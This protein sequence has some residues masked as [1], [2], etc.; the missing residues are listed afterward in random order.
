MSPNKSLFSLPG[1]V[2]I[3]S[4]LLFVTACSTPKRTRN[5]A[6]ISNWDELT[7][8]VFQLNDEHITNIDA[9]YERGTWFLFYSAIYEDSSGKH[10]RIVEISTKNFKEFSPPILSFNGAEDGWLGMANP[11]ITR[12][13]N[14]YYLSF[15]SWGNKPGKPDQLF[16]MT[17][18]DLKNWTFKT[19]LAPGLTVNAKATRPSLVFSRGRWFLIYNHDK[20]TQMAMTRGV[21]MPFERLGMGTPSFYSSTD[22]IVAHKKHQLIRFG[23]KWGLLASGNNFIPYLYQLST[24]GSSGLGWLTWEGGYPLKVQRR[25]IALAPPPESATLINMKRFGGYFYLFYVMNPSGETTQER[26]SSKIEVYRSTDLLY[27]APAGR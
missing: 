19:P 5:I 12:L 13:R 21:R 26:G 1:C 14:I 10:A 20:E 27:W 6:Y 7:N 8:P 11:S 17:S 4:F 15:N 18:R 23:N 16:Y 22:T 3:C 24:T 2:I 25:E 9:V